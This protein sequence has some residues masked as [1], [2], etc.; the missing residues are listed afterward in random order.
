MIS[1]VVVSTQTLVKHSLQHRIAL[2]LGVGVAVLFA[3]LSAVLVISHLR[4]ETEQRALAIARSLADSLNLSVENWIESIDVGLL[5]SASE[6]GRQID[7]GK[8]DA[9][10]IHRYL[11]RIRPHLPGVGQMRGTD[12][13]G[14]VIYGYGAQTPPANVA[15]RDYFQHLRAQPHSGLY[16]SKPVL[17]RIT[18][19]WLLTFVRPVLRADGR[20]A[21]TIV[22]AIELDHLA[23]MLDKLRGDESAVVS[24]RD[25]DL[26]LIVRV[27]DGTAAGI[28]VGDRKVAE[29]FK[30]QL[31]KSP[32]EGS[33]FSGGGSLDSNNRLH[34]YRVNKKH[35]FLLNVGIGET[36]IRAAWVP[37]SQMIATAA[38]LFIL[39]ALAFAF[40]LDRAWRRQADNIVSLDRS[41]RAL[42]EAERIAVLG[43]YVYDLAT[44]RW[45][46][47]EMLDEV[48]GIGPDYRR[49][50]AGW[51]GLVAPDMRE[52]MADY[53]ATLVRERLS[54][55]REYRIIR[56][57][58]GEERWV[59]GRGQLKNDDDE[60]RT[61]LFGTIQDITERKRTE[62]ELA[63]HR[64]HLETLVEQRTRQLVE[65]KEAAEA[66]N[67]AKSAFLANMSHEIRTPMNAITGMAHLIRR[68]G[69]Q[70]RQAVRLEK[71]EAASQHLLEIINTI[72]DLSKIEA[73]K[74]DLTEEPVNVHLL[75]G[76]IT[77]MLH[78][79]VAEKG[80][81]WR[82]ELGRLPPLLGDMTRLQ[83]ALLNYASNAVKFT[84][85]G[86][87]TL[88][89]LLDAEEV[90]TAVVRFVVTDTGIGVTAEVVSRLF[91]V[92]EQADNSTTRRYGGTG[93][94]LAI[95]K[96]LAHLM[97]GEV[98]VES[99]PGQGS[100]F[101]FTARLKKGSELPVVDVQN[102]E[103][104]EHLLRQRFSGY[105]I[106]LVED[107][108]INR[109]IG[110]MVLED[111][112]LQV[113]TAEDGEAAVAQAS[114]QAYTAI[115]M[116]MQMP[117]LDG[118]EATRQIRQLPGYAQIPI[119]AT[120]ANAFTEDRERCLA[121]GM[122][123]FVAK[124]LT[125]Q[126]LYAALL[127]NL[128][129]KTLPG[130]ETRR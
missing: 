56:A 48:F 72:L 46:S 53:L 9:E 75:C 7:S 4:S 108:P 62:L 11:E 89:V 128:S 47:S 37:P 103:E 67:V 77:N 2:F 43:N 52:E 5:A 40:S 90:E 104:A 69:L 55:D 115:L 3:V 33:Y 41:L 129:G 38:G 111:A 31:A 30:D 127:R 86:S 95:T 60:L 84:E 26:G 32:F 101:W 21:G 70:P 76:N 106:L 80:L 18:N 81:Q 121:A 34:F 57:S 99:T 45:T 28:E 8:V 10:S 119:L 87:I 59:H 125:P 91:T 88:R 61:V 123:D 98:G 110:V 66:A 19:K 71:L 96:K 36:Q 113:D 29:V 65:A 126:T 27:P 14:N 122:N 54:F 92:F 13:Q 42:Q 49:D 105:R 130:G 97:G 118:L 25:R 109:E 6:I 44:E 107:E 112:G 16:V 63:E 15:D 85:Q 114:A 20:F 79:Q 117:R 102:D 124:P 17:G 50:T 23:G 64:E 68:D 82:V 1:W 93:L 35:G 100:S 120:T 22:A 74:F 51:L 78:S 24:M 83:Q 116:D 58:D 94:G 39:V 73:G 12:A